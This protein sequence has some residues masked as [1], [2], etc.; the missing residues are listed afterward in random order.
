MTIQ[1]KHH[2]RSIRLEGYDYTLPGA[3]FVTMVIH[4]REPI[5]GELVDGEIRLSKLGEIVKHE[6]GQFRKPIPGSI[7]TIGPGKPAKKEGLNL[8]LKMDDESVHAGQ[9]QRYPGGVHV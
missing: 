1:L 2:R 4:Q 3:Y 9:S 7:P 6:W 5:L 8:F